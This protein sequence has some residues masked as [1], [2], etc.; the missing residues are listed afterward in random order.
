MLLFEG[1][2]KPVFL[3][4]LT[5]PPLL[6]L[7]GNVFSQGER[8]LFI[9]TQDE[10]SEKMIRLTRFAD[11]YLLQIGLFD[12]AEVLNASDIEAISEAQVKLL[13]LDFS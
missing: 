7:R 5:I 11:S 10:W 1:H 9:Y 12:V 2:L 3:L 6:S 4:W 8:F 13:Q